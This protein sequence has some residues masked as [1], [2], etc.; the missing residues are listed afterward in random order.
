MIEVSMKAIDVTGKAVITTYGSAPTLDR[1]RYEAWNGMTAR[2][3]AEPQVE[4][5]VRDIRLSVM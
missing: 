5:Q 1:A 3:A 4:R 2:L